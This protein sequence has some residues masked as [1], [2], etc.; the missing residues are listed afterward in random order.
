[1]L[2]VVAVVGSVSLVAASGAAASRTTTPRDMLPANIKSAGVIHVAT[3]IY[4]PVDYYE[5]NGK[6]LTG[7][8]AAIMQ[9]AAKILGVKI[10]WS[11]I[12]FSAIL[13]G[14]AS[15]QYDFATDLTDTAQR[16]NTVDFITTFRDGTS[17]LVKKGNPVGITNLASLCGKSVVMTQGSVQIPIE[18]A[19]SAKCT[20]AGK[21]KITQLLVPDDPPARLALKSGQADAYLANTLASSYAAKTSKD[22]QVLPGV[23]AIQYDGDIFPKKSAQLR[24]AV[25]AAINV[26]IKNGSYAKIMKTYGLTNNEVKTS[27]VN[28]VG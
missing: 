7:F 6:T 19:Q 4:A 22:F 13:P 3:S 11:V 5:K 10:A 9:A 1:M 23:Y 28:A 14:I 8:D 27:V 25:R 12:D 2:G 15:G 24:N 26:V 16:Q 20:K 18:Q 21:G 17:I